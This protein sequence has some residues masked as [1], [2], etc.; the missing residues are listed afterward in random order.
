MEYLEGLIFSKTKF[1]IEVC[2]NLNPNWREATKEFPIDEINEVLKPSIDFA[3]QILQEG[4][5]LR[6]NKKYG[7]TGISLAGRVG[8]DLQSEHNK[9]LSHNITRP[10]QALAVIVIAFDY[11]S[12][13]KNLP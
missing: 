11:L 6:T 12:L 3:Q 10:D 1:G 2:I 7:L 4:I 8:L 9:Y 5:E 13:L